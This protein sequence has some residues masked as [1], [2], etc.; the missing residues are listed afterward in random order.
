[1]CPSPNPAVTVIHLG[2]NGELSI[3]TN[4]GN[5]KVIITKSQRMFDDLKRYAF[6]PKP[7]DELELRED[8]YVP[9]V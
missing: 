4:V 3:N 6:N 2:P 9:Q 1:M 8:F 7:A 5:H